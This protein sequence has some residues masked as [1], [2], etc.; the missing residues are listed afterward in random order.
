MK[1]NTFSKSSFYFLLILKIFALDA[2]AMDPYLM[3]DLYPH[4]NAHQNKILG[5]YN[6]YPESLTVKDFEEGE[7]TA[8]TQEEVMWYSELHIDLIKTFK[9]KENEDSPL[10]SAQFLREGFVYHYAKKRYEEATFC[11]T[12]LLDWLN[13]TQETPTQNDYQNAAQAHY[14]LWR[15][16]KQVEALKKANIYLVRSL[17][18]LKDT[19][20]DGLFDLRESIASG[21]DSLEVKNRPNPRSNK[22]FSASK[23]VQNTGLTGIQNQVPV[24]NSNITHIPMGIYKTGTLVYKRDRTGDILMLKQI[25]MMIIKGEPIEKTL[26]TKL[27]FIKDENQRTYIAFDPSNKIPV[28]TEKNTPI[29]NL[30]PPESKYLMLE[31]MKKFDVCFVDQLEGKTIQFE[32]TPKTIKIEDTPYPLA[33][34]IL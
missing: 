10:L 4:L 1:K 12:E 26:F 31:L 18:L 21:L 30:R 17:R 32:A 28:Y 34:I 33:K 29:R 27:L 9:K 19:T 16:K 13:S 8:K 11:V 14:D 15:V 5:T 22:E 6:F 20:P 7:A 2:K 23:S 25:E 24:Q 3:I